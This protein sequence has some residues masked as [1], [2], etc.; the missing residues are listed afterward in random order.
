[1]GRSG[2]HGGVYFK[3]GSSP[4]NTKS[5]FEIWHSKKV[6]M[7]TFR[8][9]ESR[10]AAHIPKKKRLK[11]DAKSKEGIFIGYSENTKGYRVFFSQNKKVEILKDVIFLPEKNTASRE[12][13]NVLTNEEE[14]AEN[15][16]IEIRSGIELHEDEDS[17]VDI[18]ENGER[19][20]FQQQLRIMQ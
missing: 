16:N 15:E 7:D 1:M 5:P 8:V 10:V 4:V 6:D 13:K 18:V 12:T 20:Q 9:F 19:T 3:T 2:E 11:L 17:E 14:E